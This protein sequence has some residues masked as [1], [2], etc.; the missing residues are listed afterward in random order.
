MIIQYTTFWNDFLKAKEDK[1][2]IRRNGEVSESVLA[3]ARERMGIISVI[4][5]LRVSGEIVYDM[6]KFR[7]EIERSYDTF[8]N[9][10]HADRSY[11]RDDHQ[12][13]GWMFVNFI[14][15]MLHYRIYAMLKK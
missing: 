13:Q 2:F 9:T 11:M 6:L 5:N 14:A 12:L 3:K 4:T 7:T 10:I 8:K 15:L 1:D